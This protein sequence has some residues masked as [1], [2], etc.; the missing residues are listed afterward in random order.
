M[1]Q[2]I[3]YRTIEDDAER[4]VRVRKAD[5]DIAC[6]RFFE[7]RGMRM[8]ECYFRRHHKNTE[9]HCVKNTD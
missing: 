2:M 3:S 4:P 5:V 8:P 1:K 9:K 6:R 7:E